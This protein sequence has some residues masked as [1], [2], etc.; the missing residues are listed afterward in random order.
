MSGQTLRTSP[1]GDDASESDFEVAI[2]LPDKFMRR[3]MVANMGNMSIYRMSGFNGDGVIN[4][5]DRRRSSPGAAATSS[6]SG[7]PGRAGR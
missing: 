5:M 3:D 1:S 4:E 7:W 6:C 2:E